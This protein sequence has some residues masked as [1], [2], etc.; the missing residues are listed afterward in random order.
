MEI[1]ACWQGLGWNE[2][3]STT[4]IPGAGTQVKP[5]HFWSEAEPSF[6]CPWVFLGSM[7]SVEMLR[8]WSETAGRRTDTEDALCSE[9]RAVKLLKSFPVCNISLCMGALVLTK[10]GWAE[11]LLHLPDCL[12]LVHV[13]KDS[14]VCEGHVRGTCG[15]ILRGNRLYF[16]FRERNQT[17]SYRR[18]NFLT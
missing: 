3:E 7:A 5:E 10:Q 16:S 18:G 1:G 15:C 2:T 8:S 11:G 17:A 13:F 9:M 6:R 12:H 4:Q 14:L